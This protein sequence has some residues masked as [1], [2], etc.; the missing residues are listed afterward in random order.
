MVRKWDWLREL[1]SLLAQR[2]LDDVFGEVAHRQDEWRGREA[3]VCCCIGIAVAQL[4]S[5]SFL[6][7]RKG[8]KED[9]KRYQ[10]QGEPRFQR[11]VTEYKQHEVSPRHF[12]SSVSQE[13]LVLAADKQ[14]RELALLRQ[15]DG[16][17]HADDELINSGRGVQPSSLRKRFQS[18]SS[19]RE[20]CRRPGRLHTLH[21]G[22]RKDIHRDVNHYRPMAISLV[23]LLWESE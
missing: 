1:V 9:L 19:H 23:P 8:L 17:I 7:G 16:N 11:L 18:P 2:E 12:A 6:I 5:R 20:A 3:I 14:D 15:L 21:E 4:I 13:S 10:E 22:L